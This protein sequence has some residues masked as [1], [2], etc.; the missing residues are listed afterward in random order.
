MPPQSAAQKPTRQES[1]AAVKAEK[2]AKKDR[3]KK[4]QQQAPMTFVDP[5]A[6]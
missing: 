1:K 5:D 3:K 4:G 2:L 6:E